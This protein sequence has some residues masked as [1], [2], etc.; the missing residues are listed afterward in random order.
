[1]KITQILAYRLDLPLRE[2]GYS[3]S[4][5]RSIRAYD[6]TVVRIETDAGIV[7]FG[8]VCPLGPA[9]LPAY[10]AGVRAGITELGPHLLGHD[11]TEVGVMGRL[12]DRH[13]KGHRTSNRRSTWLAGIFSV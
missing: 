5:G 2:G 9:Y 11:P 8:E 10:A 12:M 1:M 6:S 13:L 7:G 4:G 3:F